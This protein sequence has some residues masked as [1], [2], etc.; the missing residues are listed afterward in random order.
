MPP[1]TRRHTPRKHYTKNIQRGGAAVKAVIEEEM[2]E[3]TPEPKKEKMPYINSKARTRYDPH[4]EALCQV[5]QDAE[6]NPG[7]I[8]Y[9]VYRII[10]TMWNQ[11]PRYQTINDI[12][13]VLSCISSEFY[14]KVALKYEN[15]KIS[16][17]GDV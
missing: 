14:D 3:E 9:I 5:L 1:P 2:L 8:N 15:K 16:E 11:T 17:H 6:W 13:G 10:K 12:M 4:I 7:H